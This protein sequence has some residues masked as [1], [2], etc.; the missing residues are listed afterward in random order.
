MFAILAKI[1]NT[2]FGTGERT[3]K[4]EEITALF[5][6]LNDPAKAQQRAQLIATFD[7]KLY[8]ILLDKINKLSHEDLF[9]NQEIKSICQK[10]IVTNDVVFRCFDCGHTKFHCYCV[11]CFE[12]SDH[13]NHRKNIMTNCTGLCDCGD[14]DSI[15]P[16][17]FCCHHKGA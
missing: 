3:S 5:N 6:E 17:G 2:L 8:H 4:C 11:D 10:T 14:K 1:S 7:K 12:L 16:E 13:K 15:K 9:K